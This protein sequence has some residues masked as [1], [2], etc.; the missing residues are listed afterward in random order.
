MSKQKMMSIIVDDKIYE[1]LKKAAK[2]RD[3]NMSQILRD[4]VRKEI[5]AE[6]AT[7]RPKV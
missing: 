1:W 4:M 3:L 5:E 2:Q 6:K 7:K